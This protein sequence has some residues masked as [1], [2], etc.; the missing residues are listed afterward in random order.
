M[1]KE[2]D[3]ILTMTLAQRGLVVELSPA[4]VRRAFTLRE[5]VRLLSGVD[6]TAL[7]SGTPAE[8]LRAA[9]PLAAAERGKE[10][11]SLCDDDVVDPFR[12]SNA[13]HAQSLTQIKSAVDSIADAIVM[14]GHDCNAV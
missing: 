2:V 1:L 3:L 13:L 12:L 9:I 10:R 4:T 5:F 14:A 6:P 8:R 7:P 11:T